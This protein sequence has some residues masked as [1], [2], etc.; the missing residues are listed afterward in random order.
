MQQP[1]ILII[2]LGSQYTL[3]IG[4]TLREMGFR[5]VIFSPKRADEWLENNKP[6]AI[7][8]S[9]GSAS[10]YEDGAPQVPKNVLKA[11][12]PV[13]G[14]C[15]GMQWLADHFGGKVTPHR[16]NKEYG[17]TIVNFFSGDKLFS[18]LKKSG[19]V[20]ASHGDSV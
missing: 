6:K 4:R 9:G 14:V 2:D 16:E 7:I 11:K 8:F 20:W 10:V 15:Y 17:E 3:V 13:L 19:T 18:G 5:S 1:K 12:V